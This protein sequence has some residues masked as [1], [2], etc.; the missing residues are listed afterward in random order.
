MRRRVGPNTAERFRKAKREMSESSMGKK[1][2]MPGEGGKVKKRT[3]GEHEWGGSG[4]NEEVDGQYSG[5]KCVQ[6]LEAIG[7]T[8]DVVQAEKIRQKVKKKESL[9]PNS[10]GWGKKAEGME[11]HSSKREQVGV[12]IKSYGGEESKKCPVSSYCSMVSG[13]RISQTG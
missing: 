11:G 6:E 8:E 5:G 7:K 3:Q 4:P 13:Q 10:G 1:P 9:L 2:F 12:R